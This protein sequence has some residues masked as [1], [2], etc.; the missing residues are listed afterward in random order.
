MTLDDEPPKTDCGS[1][2]LNSLAVPMCEPRYPS[3]PEDGEIVF[4]NTH[5]SEL[6]LSC[7]VNL[8]SS[9]GPYSTGD[10]PH[11]GGQS[12]LINDTPIA[13]HHYMRS[14]APDA[15]MSRLYMGSD[16]K[17]DR[18]LS[19]GVFHI[20]EA[21][22]SES[23][24]ETTA[25]CVAMAQIAPPNIVEASSMHQSSCLGGLTSMKRARQLGTTIGTAGTTIASP[26]SS[27]Q[28]AAT[29]PRKTEKKKRRILDDSDE[30]Y[31]ES[32]A[33]RTSRRRRG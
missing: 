24:I 2:T 25:T 1:P 6:P 29:V 5:S 11:I 8:S 23:T 9:A 15:R 28:T 19:D 27:P 31:M 22:G 17:L 12:A 10:L 32:K 33:G 14:H 13:G 30:D 26:E 20:N 18:H 21:H 3:S 7:S 16:G 4:R